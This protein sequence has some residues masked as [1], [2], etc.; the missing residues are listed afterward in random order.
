[1][2]PILSAALTF[3]VQSTLARVIWASVTWWFLVG[4]VPV[5]VAFLNGLAGDPLSNIPATLWWFLDLVGFD[6]AVSL[7]GTAALVRFTIR[8]MPT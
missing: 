7:I 8:R 4:L 1:M 2:G 5:V 6:I 3:L